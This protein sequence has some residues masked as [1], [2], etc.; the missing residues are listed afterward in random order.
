VD[1]PQAAPHIA[2]AGRQHTHRVGCMAAA[3]PQRLTISR[4]CCPCRHNNKGTQPGP[5]HPNDLRAA[6]PAL[7]T[8]IPAPT[9]TGDAATWRT[10][11]NE[12]A[13]VAEPQANAPGIPRLRLILQAGRQ[14]A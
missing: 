13:T 2:H 6:P 10:H 12:G 14:G 1:A 3:L 11:S 4:T 5:A 7:A 8:Y 9:A